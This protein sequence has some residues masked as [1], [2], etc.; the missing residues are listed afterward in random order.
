[1]LGAWWAAARADAHLLCLS[2]APTWPPTL[3]YTPASP[4]ATPLLAT[5][6]AGWLAASS[7]GVN[8]RQPPP[9]PWVLGSHTR[10][11]SYLEERK[12]GQTQGSLGDMVCLGVCRTEM[13]GQDLQCPTGGAELP[14]GPAAA[15]PWLCFSG[16]ALSVPYLLSTC[17]VSGS[18]NTWWARPCSWGPMS[19]G[20]GVR[21]E[22]AG[23]QRRH[24]DPRRA[25]HWLGDHGTCSS[26]LDCPCLFA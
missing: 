3:P 9:Q 11:V 4:R 25:G 10:V 21:P 22:R 19:C 8:E 26:C 7:L 17:R 14:P 16:Q 1:M 12:G 18:R 6:R 2:S 24:P 15:G 23:G 13:D 20:G 5:V